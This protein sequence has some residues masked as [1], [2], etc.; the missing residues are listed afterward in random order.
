MALISSLTTSRNSTHAV[1]KNLRIITACTVTKIDSTFTQMATTLGSGILP[2]T[3]QV[4]HW[5]FLPSSNSFLLHLLTQQGR[6]RLMATS[7][8]APAGRES[9]GGQGAGTASPV[10]RATTVCMRSSPRPATRR[11]TPSTSE[12]R[13]RAPWEPRRGRG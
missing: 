8:G 5:A 2:N 4:L 7:E 3:K 9:R 6:A 1:T 13:G 11:S 12:M 10:A